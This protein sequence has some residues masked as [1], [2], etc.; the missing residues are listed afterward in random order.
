MVGNFNFDGHSHFKCYT[1]GA[2]IH[3]DRMP[4]IKCD[5]LHM[6]VKFPNCWSGEEF[7]QKNVT[8][9]VTYSAKN[10]VCPPGYELYLPNLSLI[11]SYNL[12][13]YKWEQDNVSQPFWIA[14]NDNTGKEYHAD[15]FSGWDKADRVR[16]LLN[17]RTT[18][19]SPTPQ[20]TQAT[21]SYL[22][23]IAVLV[24]RDR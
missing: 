8:A 13:A 22:I 7:D 19:M 6:S 5:T 9:H 10:G 14:N 1:N 2:E 16:T 20:F 23:E 17:E 15:F 21:C 4:L 11:V 12:S 3:F 24:P 18:A